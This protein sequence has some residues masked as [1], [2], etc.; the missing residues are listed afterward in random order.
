MALAALVAL[1]AGDP[2]VLVAQVDRAAI[3]SVAVTYPHGHRRHDLTVMTP[4]RWC[5]LRLF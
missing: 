1:E 2:A 5:L 3:Q 4:P